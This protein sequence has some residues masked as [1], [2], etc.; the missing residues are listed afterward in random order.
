MIHG[1]FMAPHPMVR[2]PVAHCIGPHHE[3][4]DLEKN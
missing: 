3:P 1:D 4:V 2:I